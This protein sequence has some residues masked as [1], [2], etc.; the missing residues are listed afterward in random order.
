MVAKVAKKK[1]E[2]E[3]PAEAC[4]WCHDPSNQLHRRS[5]CKEK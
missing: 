2:A 1:A 3:E 4:P 5:G